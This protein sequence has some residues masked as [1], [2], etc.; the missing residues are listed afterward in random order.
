MRAINVLL[1]LLV[2]LVIGAL[3]LEG[4]LR[5]IGR[6]PAPTLNRFDAELGWSKVPG[7]SMQRRG[8]SYR[9]HFAINELGLRDD[10]MSSP[11]KAP[12]VFRVIALGDS[13]T[14]GYTV[15]RDELFVDLLE[16]DLRAAG[17]PI[18]FV[19][20]GTEGYST[21]QEARWLDVHGAAFQPDLVLLFPYEN[22]IY[23]NGQA[24]Y[25][26]FPKP[27]YAPDGTLEPRVLA[28]P[29][30]RPLVDRWAVAG[31]LKPFVSK[32]AAE[33]T[34]HAPRFGRAVRSEFAPLLSTPPAFVA[35]AE[36]HTRGAL[37]ALQQ[38]CA[39]LGATLVVAPI[40]SN[41]A[42]DPAFANEFGSRVLYAPR[43]AWSPDRP[44]DVFLG[45]CAELGIQTLDARPA[46]R[47][48]T[49]AGEK[50]YL[51]LF[52][53]REWHF[54]PAGNAA[55]AEFL[56]VELDR[57]G[58]LPATAHGA[59]PI[60][61]A[62]AQTGGGLPTWLQ[63]YLG[64]WLVLTLGYAL[65]YPKEP[66]WTAPLTTGV[67]LGLVFSIF[68]GGGWL[69]RQIPP[70]YAGVVMGG[71]VALVL[72]FVAWKLG[73]RLMTIFELLKAFVLRGHWYLMPLVV[74]LLTIGSLLVVAA[75]SPLI[76]PFIYTL[77]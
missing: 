38:R 74:V 21:D 50:L 24:Q 45:A 30:P 4:G 16:R 75:S 51:D 40:P 1:S 28:D 3:A 11:A 48:R 65:T 33:S 22:D 10:A 43:D 44:V 29:G 23:W 34:F 46:L 67:M 59:A 61:L 35:E 56:R 13:F 32:P 2:V 68:L 37:L 69:V 36:A 60:A 66:R 17:T 54:T 27:R 5:L 73:S 49:R 63:L 72:G 6:G 47:E 26:R 53:D 77:F 58:V 62:S 18:E 8:D 39:A 31:L 20:A 55:F 42:I 64:L 14:L 76:A 57:L 7:R 9:A 70:A 41:S 19:N 15:E 71:F 52:A 25:T 12:G